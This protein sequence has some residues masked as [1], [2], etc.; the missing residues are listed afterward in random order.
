MLI[1]A[2]ALNTKQTLI[3]SLITL[4]VYMYDLISTPIFWILVMFIIIDFILGIYAA[5]RNGEINWD[6]CLHGIANKVFMGF[7]VLISAAVD[8]CLMYFGIHTAGIFHKFIMAALITKEFGSVIKN[9]E[10]GGFWMPSLL[11]E[12][13]KRLAEFSKKGSLK[14]TKEE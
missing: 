7:L 12:A 10:K 5:Y 2:I 13:N 4:L 8:F 3:S 6:V 14:D 9:A 1:N 11:K